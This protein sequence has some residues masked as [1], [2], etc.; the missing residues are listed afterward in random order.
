[1][2][3]K[4]RS[5]IVVN[6]NGTNIT[7]YC[8]KAD[9][10][11]AIEQLEVTNLASTGKETIS[12]DPEWKIAIE[13]SWEVALDAVLGPDAVSPGTRRNASLAFVGA[14]QTVTY[15]WTANAEIENYKPSGQVGGFITWSASLALSGA[16]TRTVA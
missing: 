9:L 6:F 16:P 3:R 13:G 12:G 5:N 1:M 2:P 14:T 8:N 11:A 15:S 4:A 7:Q 10:D